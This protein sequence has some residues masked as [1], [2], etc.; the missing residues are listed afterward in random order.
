MVSMFCVKTI[1]ISSETFRRVSFASVNQLTIFLSILLFLTAPLTASGQI[2]DALNRKFAF[3]QQLEKQGYLEE[4]LS[5]YKQVYSSQSSNQTYF[6]KVRSTLEKLKNYDEWLQ[7]LE[8]GLK[9][10]SNNSTLIG[11]KARAHFLSGF[12]DEAKKDWMSIIALDPIKESNYRLVSQLQ[13]QLRLYDEAIATLQLGR[14]RLGN[15]KAFASDLAGIYFYRQEYRNASQE[16]ITMV[17]I[18]PGYLSIAEQRINRFPTDSAVVAD[19]TG[20]LESVVSDSLYGPLFRKLLSSFYIKNREFQ[21]AFDSYIT[22]DSLLSAEGE[23]IVLF[24]DQVFAIGAY[25]NSEN[26]YTY[27]LEQF[28]KSENSGR[29]HIGIARSLE[30][31]A[32]QDLE[33]QNYL[34]HSEKDNMKLQQALDKYQTVTETFPGTHYALEAFYRIGDIN[35]HHVFDIDRAV[36][37]YESARALSPQSE[38]ALQATI[39]IGDCYL[40]SGDTE[41]AA[42]Y[43]TM[44][45][46]VGESNTELKLL[47]EF[48]RILIQ[49]YNGDIETVQHDLDDLF[50]RTP[51]NSDLTN[52]ILDLILFIE[53]NLEQDTQAFLRYIRSDFLMQQR[54][55]SEAEYLLRENTSESQPAAVADDSWYRIAEIQES[56]GHYER[57][58]ATF[59]ELVENFPK[60]SL[61]EKTSIRIAQLFDEKM[62][63]P[64][65]ALS[66]YERFLMLHSNSIYLDMV[67]ERIRALREH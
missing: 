38:T 60:S 18:N 4:A 26:A 50:T 21:K 56:M 40:A 61:L 33:S 67:R 36:A 48:K 10:D 22:L 66:E 34:L 14:K 52:N 11:E 37:A 7:Y 19:V 20:E 42:R 25:N 45:N 23:Q 54:K 53:E 46:S 15:P 2:D 8:N 59:R 13:Q 44:L 5:I 17:T 51:G 6:F 39:T 31:S 62:D 47:A 9:Q 43:Y 35:F 57:S 3:G 1:I 27:F 32:L 58:V 28:P 29:A 55:L 41:Q 65:S 30:Q 49:Y 16:Y 63:D 12:E 64:T 24:A